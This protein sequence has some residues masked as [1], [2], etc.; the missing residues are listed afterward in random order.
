[1]APAYLLQLFEDTTFSALVLNRQRPQDTEWGSADYI[2]SILG[3]IRR[4]LPPSLMEINILR[5]KIRGMRK[6]RRFLHSLE[7][8]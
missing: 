8:F 4:L 3:Q 1:L 7:R 6:A 2:Q 5:A